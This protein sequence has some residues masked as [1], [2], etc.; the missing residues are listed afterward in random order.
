MRRFRLSPQSGKS[1]VTGGSG[2]FAYCRGEDLDV[3]GI[4]NLLAG[5]DVDKDGHRSL[6]SLRL[7]QW[8]LCFP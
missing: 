1:P 6:V 5:V 8:W 7:P 3:L 4:A 2:A